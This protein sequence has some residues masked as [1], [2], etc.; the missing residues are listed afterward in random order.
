MINDKMMIERRYLRG[1]KEVRE[2]ENVGDVNSA[3]IARL[4]VSES[5]DRLG[6]STDVDGWQSIQCEI[7]LN[8]HIL[9]RLCFGHARTVYLE[10]LIL[11]LCMMMMML[12]LR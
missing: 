10:Q 12:V 11:A 4:V 5:E 9:C 2:G 1:G 3:W 6:S 8:P 7:G